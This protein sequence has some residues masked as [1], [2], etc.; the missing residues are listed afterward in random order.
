MK[1][2]T[3]T[4]HMF[5]EQAFVVKHTDVTPLREATNMSSSPTDLRS[6]RAT[7]LHRC[8]RFHSATVCHAG[9]Y[10][11]SKRS[12]NLRFPERLPQAVY[13][14]RRLVAA[15][16]VAALLV[17]AFL[18]GRPDQVPYGEVEAWPVPAGA[19]SVESVSP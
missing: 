15:L 12:L 4:L 18:V 16:A 7:Q 13:H 1:P 11:Q 9:N 10:A 17:L 2:T 5:S 8:E 14:R 3:E 6:V 19:E